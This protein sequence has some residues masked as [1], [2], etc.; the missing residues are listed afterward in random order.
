MFY[1]KIIIRQILCLIFLS[2]SQVVDSFFRLN[3]A[4]PVLI[5]PGPGIRLAFHVLTRSSWSRGGTGS[6]SRSR[7]RRLG[8][9]ALVLG[10]AG[11]LGRSEWNVRVAARKVFSAFLLLLAFAHHSVFQGAFM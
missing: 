3:A 8:G 10:P 5:S 2:V 9:L 11:G 6:W 1:V 7:R 4:K